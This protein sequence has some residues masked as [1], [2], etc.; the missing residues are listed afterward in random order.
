MAIKDPVQRCAVLALSLGEEYAAEV[1]RH[2]TPSEV[3]SVSKAMIELKRVTRTEASEVLEAFRE[4]ADQFLSVSLGSEDY[5]RSVLN[6]ALGVE[7]AAGILD[8]ILE[9]EAHAGIDA[10]NGLEPAAIVEIIGEEHPQIIA[11][12]LVHLSRD[13]ASNVLSLL[14]ARLRADVFWRIATFEGVQPSALAALTDVLNSILSGQTSKRSKLGGVRTAAEILNLMKDADE[15]AVMTELKE[16]DTEL[17]Q[18]V[19]DEL[20]VFANFADVEDAAIQAL[21]QQVDSN[22]LVIALRNAPEALVEKFLSNTSA[23]LATIVRDELAERTPVRLS[24][25]EAERK[26]IVQLARHMADDG[27]I[28]LS[29][30]GEDEFI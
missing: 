22:S 15:T 27:K 26:K 21:L 5:I 8:D 30:T 18:K 23:R 24:R 9:P 16:R 17:A 28:S 7:R 12:I 25:V 20:F 3:Q 10:L 29:T 2:M 6:R 11:T 19:E 4:E 1:F 14:P 13:R